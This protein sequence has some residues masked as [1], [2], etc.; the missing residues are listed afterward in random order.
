MGIDPFLYAGSN[1][2]EG[3]GYMLVCAVGKNI[4]NKRYIM[5]DK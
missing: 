4:M 2:M 5:S 1:I 3:S